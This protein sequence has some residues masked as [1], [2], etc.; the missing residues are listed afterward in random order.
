MSAPQVGKLPIRMGMPEEFARVATALKDAQFDEETICRTLKISRMSEVG[1]PRTDD[2]DF[3]SASEQLQ[4]FIRLFLFLK[5]VPRFE[6]EHALDRAT[7]EAFLS[8]GLLVRGE[9]G[10]DHYHSPILLYSVSGFLMVSDRHSNPDGSYFDPPSDIVFP[11][12]YGGTL[13]FLELLPRRPGNDSLDLCAGSGIGAFVLSRSNNR[14]VSADITQRATEFALF[15]RALNDLRNVEVVCG[16]LYGP[17]EDQKFDCIVAH[18]P[19]VPSLNLDTI[20]RNGGTTGELLVRRTI[21]G[22]PGRLRAG[23]IL[24][25]L[26]LGVDTNEGKFEERARTWLGSAGEEFDI[27]FAVANERTP[28]EILK[29]LAEKEESLGPEGV[30]Q[31][32]QEFK[33]SGIVKMPYGA[34]VMQRHRVVGEHEPWTTR[35]KLSDATNGDDFEQAFRF[36]KR[37]SQPGFLQTIE[38]ARPHLAPRLQVK[39]TH[40]VHEGSLVPGEYLFES[41]KPFD[42][43]G[44]VDSWLV[45]LVLRLD[46]QTTPAEIFQSAKAD[47]QLPEGF[48]LEDFTRLLAR[49]IEVGFLAPP[50]S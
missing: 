6:V 36:H 5:L 21:E 47:G 44:Q 7:R 12:I 29:D 41:D 31:L 17:V 9:F 14:A 45:P 43:V 15:S 42:A 40:V 27:I 28:R 26:S 20:W 46:G 32:E 13:R 18:P 10:E 23:G 35:T 8:L 39:V 19:Y 24:C 49:M 48:A 11:A 30:R 25:V 37:R 38:Q 3:G 1:T 34:L 4:I 16:D 33:K 2:F 50:S 22:L